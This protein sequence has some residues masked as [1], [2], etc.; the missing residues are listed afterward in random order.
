MDTDN[1]NVGC[2]CQTLHP[3][4]RYVFSFESYIKRRHVKLAI[5]LGNAPYATYLVHHA[6]MTIATEIL[7]QF[8][9]RSSAAAITIRFLL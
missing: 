8:D 7:M 4:L 6:I 9:I 5:L 3:M 2:F 1:D